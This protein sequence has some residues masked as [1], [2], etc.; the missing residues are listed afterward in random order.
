MEKRGISKKE[1]DRILHPRN[2]MGIHAQ[3]CGYGT[4]GIMLLK[5]LEL[6]YVEIYKQRAPGEPFLNDSINYRKGATESNKT[7]QL[8]RDFYTC[9]GD[10][11]QYAEVLMKYYKSEVPVKRRKKDPAQGSNNNTTN[12]PTDDTED[13]NEAFKRAIAKEID[14][15]GVTSFAQT[16]DMDY[17]KAMKKVVG[18]TVASTPLIP[19]SEIAQYYNRFKDKF[20]L[21]HM[22]FATIVSHRKD[23]VALNELVFPPPKSTKKRKSCNE[24]EC[25]DITIIESENSATYERG[26]DPY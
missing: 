15:V 11:V 5:L 3:L 2:G 26:S 8:A 16:I 1:V 9:K 18:W 7:E 12:N 21:T 13:I 23:K 20:P 22:V 25:D 6:P 17:Q 19:D 24:S 4:R 14:D 10:T